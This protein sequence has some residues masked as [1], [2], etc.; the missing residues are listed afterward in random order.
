MLKIKNENLKSN[1][2]TYLKMKVEILSCPPI[3]PTETQDRH[4]TG[5]LMGLPTYTKTAQ[6]SVLISRSEAFKTRRH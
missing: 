6:W 3:L 2:S 4:H 5:N 1:E